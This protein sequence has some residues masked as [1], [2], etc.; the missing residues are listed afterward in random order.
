MNALAGQT[1][2][3]CDTIAAKL[4]YSSSPSD[5]LMVEEAVQELNSF[6][7]QENTRL[8]ELT[9]LLQEKHCTMSQ[10]VLDQKG[11]GGFQQAVP[12]VDSEY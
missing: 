11:G 9:D 2:V 10:E 12:G 8:Q 1:V 4:K 5:S 3:K 6:L 7:A